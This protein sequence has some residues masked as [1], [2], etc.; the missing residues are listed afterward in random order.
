M[1]RMRKKSLI[2]YFLSGLRSTSKQELYGSQKGHLMYHIKFYLDFA[3]LQISNP[4]A[5]ISS[6]QCEAG[7]ARIFG[8]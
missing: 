5:V 1:N 2:H 8:C 4:A 7:L 6:T 3:Y